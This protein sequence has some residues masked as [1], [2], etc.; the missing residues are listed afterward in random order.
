MKR[1]KKIVSCLTGIFFLLISFSATSQTLDNT[2]VTL[3]AN[4]GTA[5]KLESFKVTVTAPAA[6][7][8]GIPTS[9]T[10]TFTNNTIPVTCIL[11]SGTVPAP[12]A[13][14]KIDPVKAVA[15]TT[16][17]LNLMVPAM[18]TLTAPAVGQIRLT[19]D[20]VNTCPV[21]FKEPD[22]EEHKARI[23]YLN[24]YNVEFGDA[25]VS[26]NYVGHFNIFAPSFCSISPKGESHRWGFNAGIMK[27][28]FFVADSLANSSETS[29]TE[30]VK[31]NPFDPTDPGTKYLHEINRYETK[32]KLTDW[33]FYVQPLFRLSSQAMKN[34]F[35]FHLH[36]ELLASAYTTTT[37]IKNIYRDTLTMGAGFSEV[38][39]TNVFGTSTSRYN[40]FLSEYFGGG[41]TF[42]LH[43]WNKGAFFV[44]STLGYATQH[45]TYSPDNSNRDKTA[46]PNVGVSHAGRG[47][48]MLRASYSHSLGKE[49]AASSGGSSIVIGFDSRNFF[50]KSA[51]KYAAYLGFNLGVEKVIKIINE[52]T[53]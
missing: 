2:G 6:P 29:I 13:D 30:N 34:N 42:D 48:Y 10:F 12:L 5:S 35:Y 53:K 24:A 40:K 33:S 20:A 50:G 36:A 52:V 37:T 49:D 18:K 51:P 11:V 15:T 44:Q 22:E 23:T 25:H 1:L 43:P 26:N 31:I 19:G 7:I 32:S 17:T 4:Y 47:F 21:V 38:M 46:V 39:R 14:W 28:N 3:D 27:I 45:I 8:A 9:L 16:V 41:L